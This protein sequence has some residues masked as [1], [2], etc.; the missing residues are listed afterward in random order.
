MDK[1][2]FESPNITAESIDK[3]AALFPSAITESN[4]KDGKL[5]R[6]INFDMLRTILGDDVAG[7]EV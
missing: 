2:K 5:H 4:D 1:L 7:D 3:I 6:A